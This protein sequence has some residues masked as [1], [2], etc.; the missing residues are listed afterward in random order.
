[1]TAL[2]HK[3]DPVGIGRARGG[4]VAGYTDKSSP[5][6]NAIANDAGLTLSGREFLG[7]WVFELGN[8]LSAITNISPEIPADSRERY[9]VSGEAGAAF[10]DCVFGGKLNP[11][12]SV[13]PPRP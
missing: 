4:L 5:Y 1:M 3:A 8:A 11:S 2:G 10:E 9:G 6:V 12:G 7:L 13:S